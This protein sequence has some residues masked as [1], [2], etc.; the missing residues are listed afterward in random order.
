MDVKLVPN[1]MYASKLLIYQRLQVV[2]KESSS[3]VVGAA[4][5]KSL[6]IHPRL[7]SISELQM[8]EIRCAAQLYELICHLVHLRQQFL[9]Q[10][11]DSVAILSADELLINFLN[12]GM[13]FLPSSLSLFLFFL[14]LY[15]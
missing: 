11:C 3:S 1:L 14:S 7:R 9:I 10:F 12:Q 5:V 2:N 4:S 15:F 6:T 8:D 13:S